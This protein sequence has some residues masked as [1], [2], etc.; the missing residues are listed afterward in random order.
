M[1]RCRGC[2]RSSPSAWCRCGT[3]SAGSGAR[4]PV[5]RSSICCRRVT[6]A[7]PAPWPGRRAPAASCSARPCRW[8]P[9]RPRPPCASS[10]IRTCRPPPTTPPPWTGRR[11]WPWRGSTPAWS[12]WSGRTART[13]RS[14]S[15]LRAPPGC[16][17]RSAGSARPRRWPRRGPWPRRPGPPT[18]SL[19]RPARRRRR[20]GGSARTGPGWAAGPRRAP[21]PGRA[22]RTPR[23]RPGSSARTCASSWPCWT[24]TASTGCSTAT[25]AT[26]ACTCG[27][28]SRWRTTRSGCGRS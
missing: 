22:G 25:S 8:C 11:S 15:C 21:R 27:S 7:W 17:R 26:A 16:S 12:T 2:P 18:R 20:C 5:T 24:A 10:A 3:N 6:G 23:S 19:S 9:Y 1:R 14:R 28:I 4:S 13:L